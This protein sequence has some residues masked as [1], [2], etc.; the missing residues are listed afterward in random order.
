MATPNARPRG[1]LERHYRG[2]IRVEGRLTA[3]WQAE[4]EWAI[5]VAPGNPADPG[6]GG[7]TPHSY[8]HMATGDS[9]PVPE[10]PDLT[11]ANIH[12]AL[13]SG[14]RG[15]PGGDTLLRVL[16][17]NRRF[18]HILAQPRLTL[19]KTSGQT[20]TTSERGSGQ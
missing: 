10:V 5:Q 2:K 3:T 11:W 18:K 7:C 17:R 15:L 13:V 20:P 16:T 9:G 8:R 19:G 1:R 12:W 4:T 14:Y 6:L